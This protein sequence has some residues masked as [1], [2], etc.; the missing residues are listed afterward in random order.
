M[1]RRL[2]LMPQ[3]VLPLSDK[4][5]AARLQL[6]QPEVKFLGGIR[7]WPAPLGYDDLLVEAVLPQHFLT[8][9]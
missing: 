7:H 2:L 8:E 3:P 4:R 6:R 5:R 1:S 9:D